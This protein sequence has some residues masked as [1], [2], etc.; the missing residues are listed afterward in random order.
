MKK[1]VITQIELNSHWSLG[2]KIRVRRLLAAKRKYN[3]VAV[4]SQRNINGLLVWIPE[5]EY[6]KSI[7]A[8]KKR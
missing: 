8:T 2:V 6:L 5:R 3:E 7:F 4:T 1:N